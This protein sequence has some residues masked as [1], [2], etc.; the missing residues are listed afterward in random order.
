MIGPQRG[1]PLG[2]LF[3]ALTLPLLSSA[4]SSDPCTDVRSQQIWDDAT[5]PVYEDATKLAS[6]LDHRGL[7]VQCIRRSVGERIFPGEKG[8]AWF[9]TDQG[10]FEVWFLPESQSFEGLEVIGQEQ[11]GRYVYSFR[12][13]PRIVTT[14][15]SSKPISFIKHG[16]VLFEVWGNEM[17]AASL[18]RALRNP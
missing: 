7:V 5:S 6:T 15:D 14:I 11:G 13:T 16:N 4:Q 12:G 9:K 3:S 18:S 2:V 1:V 10:I 17:L 8:A